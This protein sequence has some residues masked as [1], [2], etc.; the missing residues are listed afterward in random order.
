MPTALT[1]Y[2]ASLSGPQVT[3]ILSLAKSENPMSAESMQLIGYLAGIEAKIAN[4]GLTP[5][6]TTTGAKVSVEETLGMVEATDTRS[7]EA[8]YADSYN[9]WKENPTNCSLQIIQ[10]EQEHRYL[11][12]MMT[13]DEEAAH[14]KE[15]N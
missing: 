9:Q 7:K 5:A 8:I 1:K 3:K 6:Y 14:E 10:Q 4:S 12:D 2:R 11:N 13:S 15:G